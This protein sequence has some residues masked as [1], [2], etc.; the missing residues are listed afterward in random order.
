MV[1]KCTVKF[2]IFAKLITLTPRLKLT[3]LVRNRISEDR[4]SEEV[5]VAS[6]SI[7]F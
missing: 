2:L 5:L 1:L 4:I 7:F 6:I 3:G